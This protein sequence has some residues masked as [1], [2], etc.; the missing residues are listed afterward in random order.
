MAKFE[1][2][3]IGEL[4]HR[5]PA[6]LLPLVE[7]YR[8]KLAKLTSDQGGR[9][10]LEKATTQRISGPQSRGVAPEPAGSVPVPPSGR[11]VSF[12][13]EQVRPARSAAEAGSAKGEA[14]RRG[15]GGATKV[16]A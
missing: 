6:K 13:L 16:S 4:K 15:G 8:V 3:P 2:A 10:T 14:P 7:E 5:L 1:T 11:L 9:L 12:Y